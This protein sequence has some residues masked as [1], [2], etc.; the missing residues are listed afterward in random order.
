MSKYDDIIDMKRP[1][2][3]RKA[4][5]RENRAAQFAPFSALVGYS[6]AVK[7]MA[8]LTDEKKCLS[9]GIKE[10]INGKLNYIRQNIESVGEV[11]ITYFVKDL[12][13]SGGK[14][15]TKMGRVKKI[16]RDFLCM[17]DGTNILF[18]DI[19]DISADIFNYF[20]V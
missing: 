1:F 11:S 2:S 13:K 10:I 16:G 8:R 18:D 14:Y 5:S 6:E 9:E 4:M 15:L 20:E 17:L 7:E 3:R 12:K 19:S